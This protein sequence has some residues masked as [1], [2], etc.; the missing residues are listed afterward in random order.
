MLQ[1]FERRKAASVYTDANK[2][3]ED[4]LT[5]AVFGIL[6]YADRPIALQMLK[7]LL[8]TETPITFPSPVTRVAVQLWPD[9]S[10]VPGEGVIQPDVLIDLYGRDQ[11][12]RLIIEAKRNA[13]LGRRQAIDQWRRLSVGPDETWHVFTVT[14]ISRTERELE[15]QDQM[16][17]D[18]GERDPR[19]ST[20]K[21]Y[22]R[23]IS[24]HEI[25]QSLQRFR[26]SVGDSLERSHLFSWSRDVLSVLEFIE[27]RPFEG[28]QR[29][30][31]PSLEDPVKGAPM[32][33]RGPHVGEFD[34]PT[35][36]PA[37]RPCFSNS[38][39]GNEDVWWNHG[40]PSNEVH[41]RCLSSS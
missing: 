15:L 36:C 14:N 31:P 6:A 8:G 40:C 25:A 4:V 17:E 18:S 37:S 16:L 10:S 29:L 20:W 12:L 2:L 41:S 7:V 22:R 24:W 38:R 3:P 26:A 33:W 1:I 28:F 27:E 21:Q 5:G 13:P 23:C 35:P 39:K 19:F 30:S 9:D 11:H 34:W 32:F